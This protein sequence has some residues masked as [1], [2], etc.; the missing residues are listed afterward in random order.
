MAK[1]ESPL[2][3]I[4][5]KVAAMISKPDP[6]SVLLVRD[7]AGGL[8]HFP[9]GKIVFGETFGEAIANNLYYDLAVTT[10]KVDTSAEMPAQIISETKEEHV[11]VMH[12][13]VILPD[14]AE[15]LPRPGIEFAW[16]HWDLCTS[17]AFLKLVSLSTAKI[18]RQFSEDGK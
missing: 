13:N 5:T 10:A 4:E 6:L 1:D 7:V 18:I 17:P 11:I 8:W 14:D 15:L 2:F 9:D 16:L 3:M 12:F